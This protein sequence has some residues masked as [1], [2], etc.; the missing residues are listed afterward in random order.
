MSAM[1]ASLESA[2]RGPG[3]DLSAANRLCVAC[4]ELL[5]VDGAAISLMH[6]G[7][8]SGPFGSSDGLSRRLDELQF[9]LGEGPCFEAVAGSRPVLVP[10]L[11]EQTGSGWPA[12]AGA[13]LAAGVHAVF[14]LPA[15][16]SVSHVGVLDLFRNEPGPLSD[17]D[18]IGGRL[19]AELATQPIRRLM[20]SDVA[21][22]S[23]PDDGHDRSEIAS[24]ERVEVHQATGMLMEQLGASSADARVRLRAH[25]FTT[26]RTAS[27]VAWAI[28]ERR[29]ILDS[30]EAWTTPSGQEPVP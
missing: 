22:D 2:L 20:A 10:D 11:G 21:W 19:A 3:N 12:F 15:R 24:L 28:V 7:T 18:M 16:V 29:L 14:A 27:E 30:D 26:G 6:E 17:D 9:T 13:A 5:H 8:T 1:R 25:A 23:D 4:V